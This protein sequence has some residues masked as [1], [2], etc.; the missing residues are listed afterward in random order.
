MCESSIILKN[1]HDLRPASWGKRKCLHCAYSGIWTCF[2][3]QRAQRFSRAQA[4]SAA[5]NAIVQAE[6]QQWIDDG[7]TRLKRQL[8]SENP[9]VGGE[10]ETDSQPRKL[11]SE[12]TPE[13]FE[14]ALPRN[15]FETLLKGDW[16]SYE[17][18]LIWNQA[19]GLR[20][21]N[22]KG[23]EWFKMIN[24]WPTCRAAL[25]ASLVGDPTFTHCTYSSLILLI[26][27]LCREPS[28]SN[29]WPH[30][31]AVEWWCCEPSQLGCDVTT[32]WRW[33]HRSKIL[34]NSRSLPPKLPSMSFQGYFREK[35][36][37][38][39]SS[40]SSV[41]S[42]LFHS[43]VTGQKFCQIW[44][45]CPRKPPSNLFWA[46]NCKT[47]RSKENFSSFENFQK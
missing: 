25:V 36:Q 32:I 14:A 7:N 18:R 35:M 27:F 44:D 4:N 39:E 21:W 2:F 23:I 9:Q 15:A 16:C 13:E 42:P 1:E 11:V 22:K 8:D 34:V 46:S 47:W 17:K 10:S 20:L 41:T 3:S 12:M 33:R 30:L 5:I 19:F 6:K 37:N 24:I 43:D 45:P 28:G 40:Q 31:Y 38:Y 26:L 29:A